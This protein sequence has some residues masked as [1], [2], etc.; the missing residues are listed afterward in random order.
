MTSRP[1]FGLQASEPAPAL[2]RAQDSM[3]A[4]LKAVLGR[5]RSVIA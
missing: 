5:R 4:E 1:P 3:M 2:L